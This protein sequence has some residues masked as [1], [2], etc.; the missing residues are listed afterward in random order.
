[1]SRRKHARDAVFEARF[2]DNELARALDAYESSVVDDF[3]DDVL[4]EIGHIESLAEQAQ[5]PQ[6]LLGIRLASRE[7]MRIAWRS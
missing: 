1:M 3:T 7:L 2:D 5:T 6:V 4:T